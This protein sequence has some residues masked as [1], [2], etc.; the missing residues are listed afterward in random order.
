VTDA[1]GLKRSEILHIS[2]QI[3]QLSHGIEVLDLGV[4]IVEFRVFVGRMVQE[5]PPWQLPTQCR[6][7]RGLQDPIMPDLV[8]FF[9]SYRGGCWY[10][11]LWTLVTQ[12]GHHGCGGIHS[13]R[14]S[15]LSL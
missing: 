15:R 14:R 7:F 4:G 13:T 6:V 12:G 1:I 8:Y 11:L 2:T 3:G 5:L 9:G 10:R